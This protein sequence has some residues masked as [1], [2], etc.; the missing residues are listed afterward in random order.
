MKYH[1]I[2]LIEFHYLIEICYITEFCYIMLLELCFGIP[3][4]YQNSVKH[5]INRISLCYWKFI[6]RDFFILTE[7]HYVFESLYM[8]RLPLC[9]VTLPE[10]HYVARIYCVTLPGY[11]YIT[12]I[13]LG[14]GIMWP[15][16]YHY[17]IIIPFHYQ[18]FSVILPKFHYITRFLL[19]YHSIT[20]PDTLHYQTYVT[21]L[22]LQKFC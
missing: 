15:E 16:F 11:C 6:D 14:Q 12:I 9:D 21:L 5:Y 13:L 18:N 3:L 2:T 20:L 8:I 19:C 10:S 1:H 4:S 22:E 17:V 7:F